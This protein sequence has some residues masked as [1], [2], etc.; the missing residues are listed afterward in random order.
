M[1][2]VAEMIPVVAPHALQRRKQI[3][4]F[5]GT[6]PMEEATIWFHLAPTGLLDVD[7]W[8]A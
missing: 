1:L 4:A 7:V 6:T 3:V 2:R 5:V 8:Q